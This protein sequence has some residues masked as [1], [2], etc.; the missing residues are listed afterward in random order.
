MPDIQT[1]TSLVQQLDAAAG[2]WSNKAL[3]FVAFT[4]IAA[5]GYL[6]TSLM[7]SDRATKLKNVQAQLIKAKDDQLTGDLK[8]KDVSISAADQKAADAQKETARLTKEAE[9][10]KTERAEA[11]KQ[12][13][14]AK[15]DALRAKEGI[16]NAEAVSAKAG[17]EVARLQGVVANAETRRLDAERKLL[18]LQER[19]KPRHLTADQRTTLIGLSKDVPKGEVVIYAFIGDAEGIAFS[20]ELLD[21]LTAAGWSV[22][23]AGQHTIMFSAGVT[24]L[25]RS[26]KDAPQHAGSLQNVLKV[27]GLGGNA[28]QTDQVPEG[29]VYL[30]VGPKP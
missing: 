15:A 5:A 6:V 27:A 18:E 17:V 16:A 9:Q 11:D 4:A 10:A 2:W 7:A 19:L 24:I 26:A 1:L 8:S 3:W 28:L 29:S 13:A 14:I 21:A 22:R 23:H 30:F 25:V 20:L 12:I